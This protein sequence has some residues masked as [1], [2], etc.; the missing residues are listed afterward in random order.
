MNANTD[1]LPYWIR[2]TCHCPILKTL[3]Q[4]CQD[5]SPK[6]YFRLMAKLCP[7]SVVDEAKSW[8]AVEARQRAKF[9]RDFAMA[10]A[11]VRF[12]FSTADYIDDAKREA[13]YQRAYAY[14]WRVPEGFGIDNL[15]A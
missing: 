14:N 6:A 10:P 13:F 9:K 15:T 3:G 7:Q 4:T 2:L 5:L 1:S 12:G 11:T 8:A